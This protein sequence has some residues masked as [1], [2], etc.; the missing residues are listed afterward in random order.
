MGYLRIVASCHVDPSEFET[1]VVP[2]NSYGVKG[3]PTLPHTACNVVHLCNCS[4]PRHPSNSSLQMAP[5]SP[6]KVSC[7]LS[8]HLGDLLKSPLN[9]SFRSTFHPK[10]PASPTLK[11]RQSAR[12][13]N[14]TLLFA[15][16][17][18]R[19]LLWAY[20]RR[21]QYGHG[22]N[23]ERNALKANHHCPE[24]P[25]SVATLSCSRAPDASESNS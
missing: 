7:F 22:R 13:C 11:S 6:K 1:R 14:L 20:T 3:L 10:R 19:R 25:V 12:I 4:F 5:P 2:K 21:M 8:G 23:T 16:A 24:G 17:V 9:A 18:R 15:S